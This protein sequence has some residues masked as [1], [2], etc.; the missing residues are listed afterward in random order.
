MFFVSSHVYINIAILFPDYYE[1]LTLEVLICLWSLDVSWRR[2]RR[3]RP[4][5]TSVEIRNLTLPITKDVIL[6]HFPYQVS[7]LSAQE[8]SHFT[9]R[10]RVDQKFLLVVH[11][12]GLLFMEVGVMLT[13]KGTGDSEVVSKSG[14]QLEFEFKTVSKS[15][16]SSQWTGN[17]Y[18]GILL[19]F[20]YCMTF[21]FYW[22][23]SLPGL[24]LWVL[25]SFKQVYYILFFTSHVYILGP[26]FMSAIPNLNRESRH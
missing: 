23:K 8:Y 13:L 10:V 3:S 20:Q 7:H 22:I 19:W 16:G 6:H 24:G 12:Y 21:V 14:S 11:A 17:L 9:A 2:E 5:L 4:Y 25:L 1:M 15:F 18:M 26:G